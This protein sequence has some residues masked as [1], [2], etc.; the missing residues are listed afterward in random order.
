MPDIQHQFLS[1]VILGEELKEAVTARITTDFFDEDEAGGYQYR[2]VWK[3]L[4]EHWTKH[5]VAPDRDVVGVA[6]P[7][8]VWEQQ[9][10]PISYFIEQLRERRRKQIVIRG[11]SDAG[12]ALHQAI[13]QD[14][15]DLVDNLISVLETSLFEAKVET[16]P[17]ELLRLDEQRSNIVETY[18]E[19]MSDPGYLRGISTGFQGIDYVT[20]GLQPEQFIV[21]IGKPKNFKSAMLLAIAREVHRTANNLLFIG[22]EMSV[23]EQIDRL[24]SLVSGVSL[25]K[26]MNGNMSTKD[27]KQIQ[28]ALRLIEGMRPWVFD[29]DITATATVSAVHARVQE[30]KPDVVFIDGAYLMQAEREDLTDEGRARAIS[31]GLKRMAQSVKVP[32]VVTTQAS[33]FRTKDG[34]LTQASVMYS[35]AWTQDCDL[36]LG[37]QRIDEQQDHGPATIRFDV[38]ASRSGPRKDVFIEWDWGNGSYHEIDPNKPQGATRQPTSSFSKP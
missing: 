11:L 28:Q 3:Y 38:L 14:N 27:L 5:G 37:V 19:R 35:Q 24:M 17:S 26:I 1:Q 8:Y 23:Q 9:T 30:L 21:L 33:Q 7:S 32:V 18:E 2:R 36:M 31:R 6:F 22:F 16:S 34:K 20:G 25:T 13:E 4:L 10:Q 29:T 12:D 15:P